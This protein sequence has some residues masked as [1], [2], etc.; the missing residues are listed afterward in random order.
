MSVLETV[1]QDK[2]PFWGNTLVDKKLWE[3]I[4]D[5]QKDT[6]I[7]FLIQEPE[8]MMVRQKVGSMVETFSYTGLVAY[9][10]DCSNSKVYA[11]EAGKSKIELCTCIWCSTVFLRSRM[12]A[13]KCTY[14][15]MMS[16]RKNTL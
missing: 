13:D 16:T 3:M 10:K 1:G 7:N 15:E 6:T 9:F 8:K 5:F 12:R 14:K 4:L 2:V 11:I